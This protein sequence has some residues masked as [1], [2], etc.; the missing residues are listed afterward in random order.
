MW[1]ARDSFE[2]KGS[3]RRLNVASPSSFLCSRSSGAACSGASDD[4]ASMFD[5]YRTGT[6]RSK[7]VSTAGVIRSK[8]S[9]KLDRLRRR[10]LRLRCRRLATK[11]DTMPV[12]PSKGL[13][14]TIYTSKK[15]KCRPGGVAGSSGR[16]L[17]QGDTAISKRGNRAESGSRG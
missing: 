8:V 10:L 5:R 15:K 1:L 2:R 11:G 14:S 13:M 4:S 3:S 7:P 12:G 9:R 16:T 6:K 17:R